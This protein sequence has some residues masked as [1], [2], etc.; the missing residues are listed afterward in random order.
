M[1][2][3]SKFSIFAQTITTKILQETMDIPRAHPHT[4]VPSTTLFSS[5]VAK[6]DGGSSNLKSKNFASDNSSNSEGNKIRKSRANGGVDGDF[7]SSSIEMPII[8]LIRKSHTKGETSSNSK[9]SSLAPSLDD[10]LWL[11]PLPPTVVIDTTCPGYSNERMTFS[12]QSS[13]YER[14]RNNGRKGD[15]ATAATLVYQKDLANGKREETGEIPMSVKMR[16]EI[17]LSPEDKG[18]GNN[19]MFFPTPKKKLPIQG[20]NENGLEA[21]MDKMNNREEMRTK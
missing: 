9:G 17:K 12:D 4:L 3:S 14:S 13:T 16:A 11:L 15:V 2:P 6:S 7:K 19:P 10:A 18:E 21:H 1:V 8:S 5:D 20:Q